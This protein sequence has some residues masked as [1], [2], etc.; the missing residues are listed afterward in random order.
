[1]LLWP[2]ALQVHFTVSPALIVTEEG[3]KKKPPSP[4]VTVVVAAPAGLGQSARRSPI[5]RVAPT[6]LNENVVV[7]ASLE[8]VR[9]LSISIWPRAGD[10]SLQIGPPLNFNRAGLWFVQGLG[11]RE[12]V[13]VLLR[14]A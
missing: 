8:F 4:T 1:M 6:L 2:L 13:T 11:H 7:F 5:N 14:F 10:S 9:K 3:K 12:K